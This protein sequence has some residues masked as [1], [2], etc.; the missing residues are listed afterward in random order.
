MEDQGVSAA[1]LSRRLGVS[2]KHVS[3]LLHGEASLSHEM[4]L[5]L[6]NVTGVPARIWNLHETGYRE[7][8]ARR[9]AD[10]DLVRQYEQAKA[11]PLTYLRQRRIRDGGGERQ[12]RHGTGSSALL[13]CRVP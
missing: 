5:R 8:L 12:G 2:R 10:E 11:F 6:E 13:W 1:E 7:A 4:A 3:K 9:D